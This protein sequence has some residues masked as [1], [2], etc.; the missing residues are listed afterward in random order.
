MLNPE[1]DRIVLDPRSI[2][3]R[4]VSRGKLSS[5]TAETQPYTTIATM[6]GML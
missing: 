2:A 5:N 3:A 6:E 1:R 4:S